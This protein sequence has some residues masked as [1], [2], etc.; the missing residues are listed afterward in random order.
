MLRQFIKLYEGSPIR[1]TGE[2]I[3]FVWPFSGTLKRVRLIGKLGGY[4]AQWKF[5][6]YS[7]SIPVFGAGNWL[8]FTTSDVDDEKAGLT[9]AVTE[10]QSVKLSLVAKGSGQISGPI[11]L[12]CEVDDGGT[13]IEGPGSSTDNEIPSFDGTSGATLQG[14]GVTAEAGAL[15]ASSVEIDGEYTLPAADGTSGQ[16][17]TTDGSGVVSWETPSGGGGGSGDVSGPGSSTDDHIVT[18]DG[19]D[20]DTVQDS[21][22]AISTDGTFSSNS[23]AKIPTEK[24]VKTY[25]DGHSGGGWTY[26][27][28]ASDESRTSNTTASADADFHFSSAANSAYQ[29]RAFVSV[30]PSGTGGTK[31]TLNASNASYQHYTMLQHKGSGNVGHIAG[32]SATNVDLGMTNGL[33]CHFVLEWLVVTS[34]STGTISIDW[35]QQ[36]SNS[37]P[38]SFLKGSVFQYRK[39]F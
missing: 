25:V 39:I 9:T 10:G 4:T 34:G 6:L 1:R 26:L 7:N 35:A 14:S 37:N 29:I 23:D 21:G 13:S 28:K 24:A 17:L 22:A 11:T 19:T 38:T 33:L 27:Y 30:Y 36:S 31:V 20:G 15:V 5:E 12:L 3:Y 32:L 8:T 16:V 2:V 18:W